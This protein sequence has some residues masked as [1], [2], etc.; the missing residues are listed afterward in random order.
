MCEFNLPL[1]TTSSA[2][3]YEE[4]SSQA[5][6]IVRESSAGWLILLHNLPT[7]LSSARRFLSQAFEFAAMPAI[8]GAQPSLESPSSHCVLKA[9]MPE[10][11]GVD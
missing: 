8:P 5:V 3:D 2:Q 9:S 1:L 4:Q 10:R 7:S 11:F 6:F